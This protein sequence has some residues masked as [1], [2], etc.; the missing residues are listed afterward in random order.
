MEAEGIGLSG[1]AIAE[2]D[3]EVGGPGLPSRRLSKLRPCTL[4]NDRAMTIATH[5][6]NE[7]HSSI[8]GHIFGVAIAFTNDRPVRPWTRRRYDGIVRILP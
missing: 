8:D 4:K 7:T 6:R 3:G 5:T 1:R 2:A